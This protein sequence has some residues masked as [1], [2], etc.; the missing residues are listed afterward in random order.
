MHNGGSLVEFRHHCPLPFFLLAHALRLLGGSFRR[1]ALGLAR[2]GRGASCHFQN[3]SPDMPVTLR[4]CEGTSCCRPFRPAPGKRS[5]HITPDAVAHRG[6]GAHAGTIACTIG[7]EP[8]VVKKNASVA[9]SRSS[10]PSFRARCDHVRHHAVGVRKASRRHSDWVNSALRTHM[11]HWP[12]AW[13]VI[14]PA[15]TQLVST[16]H[17]LVGYNQSGYI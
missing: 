7:G 15:A 14:D 16:L 3:S 8:G 1:P 9:A 6:F 2:S 5:R 10:G 17:R 12:R 4:G 13:K 11:K